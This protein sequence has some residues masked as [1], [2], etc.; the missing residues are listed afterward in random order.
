MT[1]ENLQQRIEES[2]NLLETPLALSSV[3]IQITIPTY[4]RIILRNQIEIM[5]VMS[6]EEL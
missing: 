1:S 3:G 5:R 4:L 2:Q 6:A